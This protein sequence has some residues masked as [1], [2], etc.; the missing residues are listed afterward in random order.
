[1]KTVRSGS[2]LYFYLVENLRMDGRN[3]QR[4]I[5]P[6]S[7]RQARSFGYRNSGA[8]S[9]LNAVLRLPVADALSN[10]S[11]EHH[12]VVKIWGE[13]GSA[14]TVVHPRQVTLEPGQIPVVKFRLPMPAASRPAL[15]ISIYSSVSGHELSTRVLN[16]DVQTSTKSEVISE[17]SGKRGTP[18]KTKATEASS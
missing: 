12:V 5:R 15:V 1:M 2:H 14:R 6:L 17:T 4:I 18:A 13:V 8:Y 11:H 3:V 9:D 7:A 10:H 16:T